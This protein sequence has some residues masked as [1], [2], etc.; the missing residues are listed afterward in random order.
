MGTAP[1]WG[2]LLAFALAPL[3]GIAEIALL[4]AAGGALLTTNFLLT[5]RDWPWPVRLAFGGIYAVVASLIVLS[6]GWSVAI[7]LRGGG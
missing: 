5:N 3:G 2:L 6:G 7:M 4:A 1:I